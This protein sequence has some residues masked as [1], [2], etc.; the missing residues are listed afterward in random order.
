MEPEEFVNK[1]KKAYDDAAKSAY[2]VEGRI[3]RGTQKSISALSED[4]FAKYVSELIPDRYEIWI[5]PQ[6]SVIGKR[7]K[8]GKKNLLIRPDVCVYDKA[9]NEIKLIFDLKMDLGYHRSGFT[10][11]AFNRYD[12]LNDAKTSIGKWRDKEFQFSKDLI[13]NFIVINEGNININVLK[14]IKN[15]IENKGR[16]GFFTLVSGDHL[17]RAERKNEKNKSEINK[18]DFDEIEKLIKNKCK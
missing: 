1:I 5:D 11:F 12:E 6:I 16:I 4:L 17:N 3:I 14:K 7:N 8:T 18:A 10:D 9:K 13:W 2:P 15:D